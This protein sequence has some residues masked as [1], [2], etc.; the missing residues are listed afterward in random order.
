MLGRY[1]D[2]LKSKYIAG[3]EIAGLEEDIGSLPQKIFYFGLLLLVYCCWFM[4]VGLLL[5]V[6]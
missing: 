4:V 2:F 5:L 1:V 6:S 3:L